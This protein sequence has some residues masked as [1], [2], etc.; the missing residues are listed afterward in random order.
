M[1]LYPQFSCFMF[2][3]KTKPTN[4]MVGF[5]LQNVDAIYYFPLNGPVNLFNP[6]WVLLS[7]TNEFNQTPTK[8]LGK[9]G[10]ILL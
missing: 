8:A 4:V 3:L 6:H 2:E 7:E 9:H 1:F 10:C 5:I